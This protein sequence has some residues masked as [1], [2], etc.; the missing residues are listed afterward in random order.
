MTQVKGYPKPCVI[1]C[2]GC[3]KVQPALVTFDV[4]DPYPSHAHDCACGYLIMESEWEEVD[5]DKLTGRRPS[6]LTVID[7]ERLQRLVTQLVKHKGNARVG[8]PELTYTNLGG[9]LVALEDLKA[10]VEASRD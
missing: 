3:G 4:H 10:N 1:R 5:L 7:I 8:Q 2:P 6:R 9:L